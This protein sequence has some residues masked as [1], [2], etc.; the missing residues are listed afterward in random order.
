MILVFVYSIGVLL[1]A[2]S[3]PVVLTSTDLT[4]IRAAGNK[5]VNYRNESVHI[6][7]SQ[8]RQ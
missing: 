2:N 6:R 4:G 8:W 5:L 1:L 3:Q 7:V